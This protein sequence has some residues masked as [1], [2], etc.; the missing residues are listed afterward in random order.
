MHCSTSATKRLQVLT[1]GSFCR[2]GLWDVYKRLR[3][4]PVRD[5]GNNSV[6]RSIDGGHRI[7]VLDP[8]IDTR[9]VTGR[10]DP[11]WQVADRNGRDL[12]EIVGSKGL[13]LVQAA[14]RDI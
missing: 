1:S 11:M 3:R 6:R 4:L 5:H 2:H 13:H 14:N 9:A 10:P 12:L 7:S 8:D